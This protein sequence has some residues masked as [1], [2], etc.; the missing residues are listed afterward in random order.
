MVKPYIAPESDGKRLVHKLGCQAMPNPMLCVEVANSHDAAEALEK[1]K[2]QVPSDA[3]I[4][5]LCSLC[6]PPH[7]A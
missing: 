2:K 7:K 4:M 1:A 5:E 3:A 6:L